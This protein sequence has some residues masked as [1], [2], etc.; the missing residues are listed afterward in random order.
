MPRLLDSRVR[1]N[2]VGVMPIPSFWAE[3][4][5]DPESMPRLLDSR[6]RGNDGGCDAYPV[7]PDGVERRSGIYAEVAGF[8]RSRE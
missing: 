1:G 8:P 7:I 2:D 5:G 6:V 3:W 4:N